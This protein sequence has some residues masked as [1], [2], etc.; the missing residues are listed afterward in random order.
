V[1]QGLREVHEDCQWAITL[2][3]TKIQN[4]RTITPFLIGFMWVRSKNISN[5]CTQYILYVL[6]VC[7]GWVQ[8]I[9]LHAQLTR[10]GNPCNGSQSPKYMQSWRTLFMN[11]DFV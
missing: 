9:V 10:F 8:G 11:T 1:I 4:R 6:C 5:V 3:K 7:G 2:R